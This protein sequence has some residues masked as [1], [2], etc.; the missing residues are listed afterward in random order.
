MLTLYDFSTN[1]QVIISVVSDSSISLP[2]LG[3]N[4]LIGKFSKWRLAYE[5]TTDKT[6][7]NTTQPKI[8]KKRSMYDNISVEILFCFKRG[9]V[10]CSVYFILS[11]NHLCIYTKILI[12][13]R[14]SYFGE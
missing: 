1:A 8:S 10:N 11:N 13:L 2:L 12:R 7:E 5:C 3:D 6:T 14:L 4:H 9:Y